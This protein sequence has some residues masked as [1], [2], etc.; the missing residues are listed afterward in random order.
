MK[1]L[2]FSNI[3]LVVLCASI[4]YISTSSI[5]KNNITQYSTQQETFT[6]VVHDHG[7]K[8]GQTIVVFKFKV[9]SQFKA[10][11]LATKELKKTTAKTS[12]F[13]SSGFVYHQNPTLLVW[14][15]FISIMISIAA[16]SVPIFIGLIIE[17]KDKFNLSKSQLRKGVGYALILGLILVLSNY[18]LPGY[19][20][21]EKIIDDFNILLQN[22]G[23]LTWIVGVTV[24]LMMPAFALVFMIGLSSNNIVLA[25][26]DLKNIENAVR[27]LRMLHESLRKAVQ[28]LSVIVVFSVLT[29][30]MLGQAIKSTIQIKGFDLYPNQVSYV[31]GMYFTLFLCILYV[32][33]YYYIRYHYSSLKELAMELDL[34][35]EHAENDIYKQLFGDTQFES[36]PLNN[37]KLALT[38]MAPIISG[39][40]PEGLKLFE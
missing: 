32:P 2:S 28:I 9:E 5:I 31:Y 13:D 25:T 30:S 27:K 19:Y 4:G 1:L 17:L 8:S 10:D 23:I 22:G 15:M 37:F 20:K 18:S 12:E 14:T 34:D 11:S 33:V 39:I 36:S 21:P 24:F 7:D 38:L 6:R 3:L 29:S 40:L 26:N 35:H 16:G